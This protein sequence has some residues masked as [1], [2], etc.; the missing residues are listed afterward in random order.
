[1][2]NINNTATTTFKAKSTSLKT[3]ARIIELFIYYYVQ[4]CE[5]NAG[6]DC[7]IIFV[8]SQ[9]INNQNNIERQINIIEDFHSYH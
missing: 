3:F 7:I 2:I 4:Y 9:M 5:C 8:L 6:I 1:M